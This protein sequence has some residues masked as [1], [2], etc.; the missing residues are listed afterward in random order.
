VVRRA[1]LAA[2]VC[3]LVWG[4]APVS[5]AGSVE[6]HCVLDATIQG[7]TLTIAYRLYAAAPDQAWRVRFF[8]DDRR[9]FR[10]TR[11]TDADGRFRVVREYA[12]RAG[13]ETIRATARHLRTGA[14]C[15]I[16]VRV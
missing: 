4:L 6:G 15:A 1:L 11:R 8:R 7:P 3:A 12:N 5:A 13:R 14:V 10:G 9:V 2:S 16:S